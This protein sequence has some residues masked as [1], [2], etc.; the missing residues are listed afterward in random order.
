MWPQGSPVSIR[1]ER[2]S[3]GLLSNHC[4]GYRPQDAL[5]K[6]SRSLSQ[7]AAGNPVFPRL[8]TVTL[9]S[10]SGAYGKSGI[11]W[12]WEG[13]LGTPLGLVRWKRSHPEL[14]REPQGSSPLLMWVLGCVC[15]FKQGVRS[16]RV[17]RH[18]TLLSFSVKCVKNPFE[19]QG[20]HGLS[21]ET[22][23]CKRDSSR[24]RGEFLSLCGVGAGS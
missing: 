7:V 4:R 9:G 22:L 15:H 14:T 12:C 13:P 20:K 5:M 3:S 17:W 21:L 6:E 2:G 1:H 19:F 18:G 10:F 16:R 11:L 24:R 23:Q 8:V